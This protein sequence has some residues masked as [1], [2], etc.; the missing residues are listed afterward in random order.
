MLR[1]VDFEVRLPAGHVFVAETPDGVTALVL[2]GEGS[3]FFSPKP[4]E[5]RGQVRIFAGA[6]TLDT[7]FTAAFVRVNP[8]EFSQAPNDAC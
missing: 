2:L 6:E 7:P 3:I 8:N 4:K 1:S 5:E